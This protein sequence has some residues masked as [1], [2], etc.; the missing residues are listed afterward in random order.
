ML[1]T[2]LK[3]ITAFTLMLLLAACGVVGSRPQSQQ[4]PPEPEGLL[5]GLASGWNEFRPGGETRCSDGTEYKF[6]VRPGDANK[7]LFY[8]QGGGACWTR[9]TCDPALQPSYNINLKNFDPTRYRGIFEFD[10]PANPFK[11]HT[12]V[13]A[14]YC[15]GDVHIGALD[16]VYEPVTED[17]ELLTIYHRGFAN[18]QAVLDWTYDKIR[19]PAK[20]FVTGSS[21]GAIPSPYY[22]AV[23]AEHYTNSRVTQLG[24]AAGGYRRDNRDSRPSDRWGTFNEINKQPG[25]EDLTQEAFNY[26]KLY[27]HAAK[28]YPGITFAEYD[29][30]EDRVQRRFLAIGGQTDVKLLDYLKANQ[31]DI[32]AEVSN[33]KSYIA[34]GDSHTVLARP[35]FYTFESNGTSVRDWVAQLA[36]TSTVANVVCSDCRLPDYVGVATPESLKALWLGWEDEDRQGVKPFRIFD[37]VYYVGIDWV[38]A[39]VLKTSEG[40]ILI[41]A[42]YGK[43]VQ[44][45]VYN[46][47]QL[48]LDPNDVKYVLVT[49]GHFDHAGGAAFFQDRFGAKVVMAEE[50][51]ILVEQDAEH[52]FFAMQ[53]PKRDIVAKDGDV[54][55]LGDTRVELYNTPGHTTGVLTMKYDVKDGE[56]TYTAVTL[57]GVGLNFTGV[58][59]TEIYIKSYERLQSMQ[60]GVSVSLP[61]HAAMADVFNRAAQLK[62]RAAGDPHAFVDTAAYA[63]GLIKFLAN[64]QEKLV[65][66]KAGTAKDPL[67]E[68]TRVLAD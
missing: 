43:W 14:P 17:G 30:A 58:E 9:Q 11:D 54:I 67:E 55:E 5:G 45:L 61:N 49:H 59:R 19:N 32:S 10:N 27:I 60:E 57:G 31:A 25:F 56:D 46:M 35:E 2:I 34:G 15:T 41:D 28:K 44:R 24:D 16:A 40:L 65:A 50:D 38:S 22:A 68:L 26:E 42:L 62:D 4:Q 20:I 21:A 3:T 36:E 39:Y 8:L 7:L 66:E 18:V 23:L 48:G 33:F 6:Y 53:K 12:L 63:Q 29:A 47:R 52:P 1:K 64:A 37:N 13:F 51:W